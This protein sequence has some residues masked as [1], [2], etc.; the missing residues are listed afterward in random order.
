LVPTSAV[1]APGHSCPL[2]RPNDRF[3]AKRTARSRR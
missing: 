1:A 2:G 3:R